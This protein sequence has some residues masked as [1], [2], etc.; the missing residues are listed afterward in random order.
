MTG[1]VPIFESVGAAMRYVREN[2][3]F[4]AAVAG[5]GAAVTT[6]VS[7]LTL[8]LPAIGL[9]TGLASTFV[10]AS[11]YAAFLGAFLYGPAA[12]GGRLFPDG[13][14]VWA[15][16]AVIGFFLFIVFFVLTIPVMIILF[17][18][19]LAPYLPELQSAGGDQQAVMEVM[20]RFAEE[21]PGAL[22][23]VTLFY[24]VIWLLLTSRLYLAAPASVEQGRILTFET[25]KWTKGAT[26]RI[27]GARLLLLAPAN[28]LAGAL[29]YLVGRLVGVDA[30]NPASS[31]AAAAGNPVG[32]L[33]YL[34]AASFITFVLYS[35]LEAGLSSYMYRGLK[36]AAPPP[37]S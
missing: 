15:A 36:P 26:L 35:S 24:G 37:A 27:T 7:A 29:G 1:N 34:L 4:I 30:L 18:G 28:I 23:A 19:P 10:H 16:M 31:A 2:L 21:N 11:V 17:A 3:R 8:A 12:L 6:A 20:T 14:R 5:V 13:G 25:W 33:F 9:L 22:L 32:F